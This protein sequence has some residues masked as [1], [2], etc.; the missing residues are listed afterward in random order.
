L[1]VVAIVVA[2]LGTLIAV[3][4]LWGYQQIQKSAEIR[5][6]E[7]VN[8]YL[9][10]EGFDTKLGKMIEEQIEKAPVIKAVEGGIALKPKSE[11]TK[12]GSQGT[13]KEWDDQK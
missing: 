3:A 12:K 8:N 1:G 4:A 6:E 13:E 11:N 5:S 7:A 10:S 9:K 2:A